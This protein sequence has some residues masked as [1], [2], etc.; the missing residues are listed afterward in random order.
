MYMCTCVHVYMYTHTHAQCS[1]TRHLRTCRYA[2]VQAN[3]PSGIS[4]AAAIAVNRT[5]GVKTMNATRNITKRATPNE[6]IYKATI[7]YR[8]AQFVSWRL[9]SMS[10]SY[11][12]CFFLFNFFTT[13]AEDPV[14]GACPD[15]LAYTLGL[16][17]TSIDVQWT[18]P[19]ATDN[20]GVTPVVTS[21]RNP[22]LF[23]AGT[24]TVTITATDVAGNIDPCN[25]TITVNCKYIVDKKSDPKAPSV[26]GY[27]P[28]SMQQ[29]LLVVQ[30]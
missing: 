7:F 9:S 16:S 29:Q 14:L 27:T 28:C 21:S 8:Y 13:D 22:G 3:R 12:S 1:Y 30:V 26:T 19:T 18:N 15:S 24:Y 23:T 4:E 20:S 2:A 17:Q 25:F 10:N 5:Q 6:T 11:C